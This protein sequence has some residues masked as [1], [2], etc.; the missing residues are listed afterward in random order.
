MADKAAKGRAAKGAQHG[1]AKLRPAQ[2]RGVFKLR[3]HGATQAEIGALL[4]VCQ[5]HVSDIL[6]G[7]VWQAALKEAS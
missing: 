2:V 1:M 4:G 6:A 3:A 5:A 7:K